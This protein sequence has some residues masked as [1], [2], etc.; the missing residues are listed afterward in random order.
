MQKNEI[1]EFKD[2][3]TPAVQDYLKVI[4]KFQDKGT[5]PTTLIADELNVTGASVTG[6]IKRLNQLGL[7]DYSSYKGVRLT[8]IGEKIAL[9]I[10]RH[11]RLLE[12]YLKELM[13]YSLDKIHDEACNLEHHISPEFA[14]RLDEMLGQPKFDPHGHPI[15]TKDGQISHITE[16][17]LT[18]VEV[19]QVVTVSRLN[20]KNKELLAYLEKIEL[21]PNTEIKII[22]K[23]PF[24]GPVTIDYKGVEKIIG[25]EIAKNIFVEFK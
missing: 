24:N 7:V 15:P 1:S 16:V 9:E 13:G 18:Q 6:M 3:I 8:P 14:D 11:H 4:Y 10:L 12:L 17:S 21:L 19:G 25:N 5:V 22:D 23:G 2:K 20:D